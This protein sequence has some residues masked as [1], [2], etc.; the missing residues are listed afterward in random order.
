MCAHTELHNLVMSSPDAN[1]RL[2]REQLEDCLREELEGFRARFL[3]AKSRVERL[4]RLTDGDPS[5]DRSDTLTAARCAVEIARS[6]FDA[7]LQRFQDLILHGKGPQSTTDF[8][9]MP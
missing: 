4:E 8:R 3:Q 9:P 2:N 6:Q 7:A 5:A 1:C